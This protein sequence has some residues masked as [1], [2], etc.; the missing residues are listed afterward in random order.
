MVDMTLEVDAMTLLAG[1][2]PLG[3]FIAPGWA[4]TVAYLPLGLVFN[5]NGLWVNLGYAVL[6]AAV[7]RRLAPLQQG[8][9]W[10]QRLAGV[11]FIGFGLKLALTDNPPS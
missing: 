11:M 5:F 10:L 6:G 4:K 8:R 2:E 1:I 7:S 3:L 9:A